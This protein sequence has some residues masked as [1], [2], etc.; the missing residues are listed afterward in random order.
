MKR[1]TPLAAVILMCV[2]VG[3]RQVLSADDPQS[4][5][6]LKRL[7][8]DVLDKVKA[9][10]TD[11]AMALIRPM[12]LPNADRWFVSVF[13]P[14]KGKLLAADYAEQARTLDKDLL[15]LFSEQVKQS[16]T[17]VT[18]YKLESAGDPQATGAQVK[19]LTAMVTKVP[20]YGCRMVAPGAELGM[21]LWSFVWVDGQFRLAGKMR[22]P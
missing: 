15:G 22:L 19:A 5:E 17:K 9:G 16:R 21:H 7:T 2:A 4:P 18:A 8:E 20:L 10:N 6:G 1:I 3:P 14:E 12:R 13:G 11:A